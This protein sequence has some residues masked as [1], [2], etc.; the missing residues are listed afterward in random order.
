[1]SKLITVELCEGLC[2]K[3]RKSAHLGR[4]MKMMTTVKDQFESL[5]RGKG[6]PS[7]KGGGNGRRNRRWNK[8]NDGQNFRRISL[9]C[10]PEFTSPCVLLL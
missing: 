7:K 3:K 2:Q 10:K 5:G 6:G 9:N 1:M 4:M 8:R